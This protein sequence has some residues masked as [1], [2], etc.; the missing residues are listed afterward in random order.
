[1]DCRSA[2]LLVHG[3]V[4]GELELLVSLE[5]ERHVEGCAACRGRLAKAQSLRARFARGGLAFRSPP[6]L[7]D[8]VAAGSGKKRPVTVLAAQ[9]RAHW[10]RWLAGAAAAVLVLASVFALV[11]TPSS[12]MLLAQQVRDSHV[13]S[14]LAGH[15]NDVESSDQHTVKPWFAGH[16]DF[17][18]WAGNLADEGF[19]LQGGRLDYLD[20]HRVAALVFKRRDHVINLFIWP[21]S[22]SPTQSPRLTRQNNYQMLH[23]S[24]AGMTY[25]AVSDLNAAE[26]H[27]FVALVQRRTLTMY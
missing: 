21:S 20:N 22:D 26:L 15:L 27:E 3:Y 16:V 7:R 18:P 13:R 9:R 24:A 6:Q 10:W 1:M 14:L 4:D 5:F 2:E 17:A 23:W 8:R 11:E 12:E 19:P 25:W